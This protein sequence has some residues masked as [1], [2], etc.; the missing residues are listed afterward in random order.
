MG[1]P[2]SSATSCTASSRVDLPFA[3]AY[4]DGADRDHGRLPAR[5][6][7]APARW[8]SCS[9]VPL[10][11]PPAGCCEL[12]PRSCCVVL[13]A[14]IVYVARLSV[15]T[16]PN[17]AWPPRGFTLEWWQKA[18]TT[19]T[20][21]ATRCSVRCRPGLTAIGDR[22]GPRHARGVRADPV[23]RF[24]GRNAVSL[25]IVLPIALPGIV[26]GIALLSGFHRV[27]IDLS[28]FTTL[29]VAHATFCIV[30]VYNNVVG[31]VCAGCR[32][33]SAKRP[34]ISAPTAGRRSGYMTFP[35]MRTA[36]RRRWPPGLRAVVR[37]DHRHHLHGRSGVQDAAAVVRRQLLPA[38][39]P[40]RP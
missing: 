29:V 36:L 14:P 31:R 16:A 35:L 6:R 24:F 13:Y 27:G 9:H 37:R 5:G 21:R 10:V 26:T 20:V 1:R 3:A 32:R 12:R 39:L 17:Y 8:R 40:S 11:V 18:A 7:A 15:N 2:S 25:F 23:D 38:E 34:P 19:R 33:I 4:A 28:S 22:A 30:I